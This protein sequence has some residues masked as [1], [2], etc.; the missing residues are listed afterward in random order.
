MSYYHYNLLRLFMDVA[1]RSPG[2]DKIGRK[3]NK[4]KEKWQMDEEI[5]R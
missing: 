3:I 5:S 4:E 1:F 2:N